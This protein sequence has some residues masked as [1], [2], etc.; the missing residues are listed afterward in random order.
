[1]KPASE[2]KRIKRHQLD[3]I[4]RYGNDFSAALDQLINRHK[5]LEDYY[6]LA[7]RPKMPS[8]YVA[9]ETGDR[10]F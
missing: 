8:S 3:Y 2:V 7:R 1:M 10:V 5:V 4:Q 9:T 6:E